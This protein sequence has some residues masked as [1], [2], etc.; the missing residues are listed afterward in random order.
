M[1]AVRLARTA[2]QMS[3]WHW[4]FSC[5][6]PLAAIV[7]GRCRLARLRSTC[8]S[9]AFAPA[10]ASLLPANPTWVVNLEAIPERSAPERRQRPDRA[11]CASS[12]TSRCAAIRAS[13]PRSSIR[14]PQ[15]TGFVPS[16]AIGPTDAAA[17]LHHR[18]RRRRRWTRSTQTVARSAAPRCRSIRRP[19]PTRRP[20]PWPTTRRS[21]IADSVEGDDGE[22]WYRTADG[23]YLPSTSVRLP[24]PPARTFAGRWIDV[25][26]REPAML[27]AYDGD[28]AGAHHADDPRRRRRGRRRSACSPFSGASP[29]RR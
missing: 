4:C 11:P 16:D 17:G 27:V 10:A 23:D 9:V 22:T 8:A 7:G 20:R 19:I 15:V 6:C 21:T 13:G 12:P 14:A 29:T 25:D 18:R 26:L 24:R 2:M 1:L 3:N 28:H 5:A